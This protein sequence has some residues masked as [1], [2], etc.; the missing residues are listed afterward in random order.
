MQLSRFRLL[1]L[2]AQK[3]AGNA[4]QSILLP[5]SDDHKVTVKH[6][7]G[8]DRYGIEGPIT[9]TKHMLLQRYKERLEGLF[10]DYRVAITVRH[11]VDR[12]VS[13]Y[14]SPHQWFRQTEEGGFHRIPPVWD[15]QRFEVVIR[16]RLVPFSRILTVDGVLRAPEFTIRFENLEADFALFCN[17]FGISRPAVIPA[18]NKTASDAEEKLER[19][20]DPDVIGLVTSLFAEDFAAFGYNPQRLP[21]TNRTQ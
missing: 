7:D 4:L 17:E 5:Y 12:A 21:S 18:R 13:L 15:R 6:Q 9:E 20:N 2:H 10:I 19:C 1:Y 11:P 3:T 8:E 14:Y 16:D